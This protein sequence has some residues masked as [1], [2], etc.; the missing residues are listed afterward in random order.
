MMPESAAS[1]ATHSSGHA[2]DDGVCSV[3]L[4]DRSAADLEVGVVAQLLFA[5]SLPGV[6]PYQWIG[7]SPG[8]LTVR[9]V[10]TPGRQRAPTTRDSSV[11]DEP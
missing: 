7:G 5:E 2:D 6:P 8:S 10:V 1:K 3:G 9:H 11:A 4:E